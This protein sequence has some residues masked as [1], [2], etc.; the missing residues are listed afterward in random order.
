MYVRVVC[1][2]HDYDDFSGDK[3]DNEAYD[4]NDDDDEE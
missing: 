1:V 3:K 2:M 4:D